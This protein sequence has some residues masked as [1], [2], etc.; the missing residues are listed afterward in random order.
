MHILIATV[1]V[2]IVEDNIG[3]DLINFIYIFVTQ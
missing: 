3:C 2:L 1:I